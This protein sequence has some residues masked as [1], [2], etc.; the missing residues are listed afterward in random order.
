LATSIDP[1]RDQSVGA[2]VR[3]RRRARKLSQTELAELAGVGRR[4]VSEIE[5]GKQTVR[6]D[7]CNAV[8][9][10]FGKTLGVVSAARAVEDIEDRPA[11]SPE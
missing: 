10:V 2:F 11:R 3:E 1:E 4:L 5:R 9:A 8:L 7:A 6:L